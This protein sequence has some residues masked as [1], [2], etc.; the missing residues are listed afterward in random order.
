MTHIENESQGSEARSPV[1]DLEAEDI[2]P[3]SD[4]GDIEPPKEEPPQEE[5]PKE[6]QS[7]SPPPSAREKSSFWTRG[8]IAGV[9]AVVA[10]LF[11]AWAYREFGA[12]WWPPSSMS[13]L[14]EKLGTLEASNRTLND[15]LV[16]LSKSFD[17]F[18]SATGSSL[19]DETKARGDAEG[20]LAAVEKALSEMRQSIAGLSA[21]PGGS[22]DS[23]A[24]A[25]ITRRRREQLQIHR[26]PHQADHRMEHDRSGHEHREPH[27]GNASDATA[28]PTAAISD[29]TRLT[30]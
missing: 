8:R 12:P 27:R 11:G 29:H 17:T 13:V 18:K 4:T 20:R 28:M 2:S 7:S 21:S 26:E 9:V 15:Q 6:E 24:L 30:V 22:V 14:E 1:I 10:A 3:P 5:P 23:L 16:A 25:D 19:D